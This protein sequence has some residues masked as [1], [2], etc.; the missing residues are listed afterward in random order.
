MWMK[1][2]LMRKHCPKSKFKFIIYIYIYIYNSNSYIVSL[3][4]TVIVFRQQNFLGIK[5]GYCFCNRVYIPWLKQIVLCILKEFACKVFFLYLYRIE[6]YTEK[7]RQ[8]FLFYLTC[9]LWKTW[10]WA[11]INVKLREYFDFL[12]FFKFGRYG[13]NY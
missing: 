9:Q 5:N 10:I 8:Y 3:H 12:G 7:M 1:F 6:Q 11:I 13:I 4:I 2:I